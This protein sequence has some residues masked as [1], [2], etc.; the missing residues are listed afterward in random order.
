MLYD[1]PSI[2][3]CRGTWKSYLTRADVGVL[4]LKSTKP[5][6]IAA[7]KLLSKN[8]AML[9]DTVIAIANFQ[10]TVNALPPVIISRFLGVTTYGMVAT[11]PDRHDIL[12]DILKSAAAVAL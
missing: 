1:L 3:E 4:V 11:D 2:E 5:G 8:Q 6:V 10:D 12:Q 9:P 7:K